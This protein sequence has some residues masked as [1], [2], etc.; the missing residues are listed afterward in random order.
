M[1]K[2]DRIRRAATGEDDDV[3]RPTN[4]SLSRRLLEEAR[5]HGINISRACERGLAEQV[6]ASRARKWIEEN[7]PAIRSSN[8]HVEEHGVPLARH[9]RF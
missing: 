5:E 2:L 8:A 4:V 6:A 7:T 1:S 3:K 9:R